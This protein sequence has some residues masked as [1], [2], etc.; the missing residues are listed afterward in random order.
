MENFSEATLAAHLKELEAR[1]KRYGSKHDRVGQTHLHIAQ[2]LAFGAPF[3]VQ[4]GVLDSLRSH[5]E[6]TTEAEEHLG[7]ALSIF[8]RRSSTRER[9]I[10]EALELRADLY[11]LKN[12]KETTAVTAYL[13]IMQNFS[14]A[15]QAEVR[16][17]SKVADVYKA[18][19]EASMAGAC[20]SAAIALLRAESAP[21]GF[22]IAVNTRAL[23]AVHLAEKDFDKAA[24]LAQCALELFTEPDFHT[25]MRGQ[26]ATEAGI[27][28]DV[29]GRVHREKGDLL[30]ARRFLQRALQVKQMTLGLHHSLVGISRD[31]LAS[32]LVRSAIS[33][34]PR[35]FFQVFSSEGIKF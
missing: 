9:N 30:S 12:G 19:G 17:L 5:P 35:Y 32:V 27:A 31:H 2:L 10:L 28:L 1:K 16:L 25:G 3:R 23:A 24:Q 33:S 4:R 15:T 7:A 6:R 21:Q 22:D 11:A 26:C 14:I 18:A 29:L 13:E 34:A 20:Y 8:R